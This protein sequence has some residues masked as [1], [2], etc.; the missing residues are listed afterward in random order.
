MP[1]TLSATSVSSPVIIGHRGASAYRPEH[2]LEAYELAARMGADYIEPD[3]APTKDGVLVAR[4]GNYLTDTT[5]VASRPDLAHLRTTKVVDGMELTGW[6]T[7]DLTLAELRTLRVRVRHPH[8]WPE[9]AAHD[10]RLGIPTFAEVLALRERLCYELDREIG[11]YPE[12]KHP[13]YFKDLGLPLEEPL[14]AALAEHGL[15][16]PDAPVFVQSFEL[17]NL[18]FMHASLGLRTRSI[19]LLWSYGYPWDS[20]AAGDPVRDYAH[21]TTREGLAEVAAAGV[22]G[23][24]PELTMVIAPRSDGSTGE[25]TGLVERAHAQGLVVHPYT[26]NA[27]NSYLYTDF[28]GPDPSGHGDLEGQIRAFLELGIDGFFTDNPDIGAAAA[29]GWAARHRG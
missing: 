28:R 20:V 10:G 3:L 18:A 24:G 9:A 1:S 14:V 8:L 16:R 12:T 5:D 25:D 13:S 19:M 6:F 29:E 22:S 27:Q 4:H 2:T 26:F 21:Y 11:V 7:E 17:A 15:N 23:I